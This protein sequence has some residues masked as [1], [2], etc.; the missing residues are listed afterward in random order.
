MNYTIG[1]ASRLN[2][3][4][5]LLLGHRWGRWVSFVGLPGEAIKGRIRECHR[6]GIDDVQE[7]PNR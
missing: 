7:R 3:L 2:V 1:A 6:C 5:C 4:R